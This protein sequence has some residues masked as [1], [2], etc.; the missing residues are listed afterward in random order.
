[1]IFYLKCI[2]MNVEC[3]CVFMIRKNIMF[4]NIRS[5]WFY[6]KQIGN[7]NELFKF[8]LSAMEIFHIAR[9]YRSSIQFLNGDV[10]LAH[11]CNNKSKAVLWNCFCFCLFALY[12]SSINSKK[13]KVFVLYLSST[14][15]F[16]F[17]HFVKIAQRLEF[18][19][20]YNRIYIFV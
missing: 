11:Y 6:N 12:F 14:S 15:R 5:N 8:Y 10:Y 3:V 13:I 20:V 17:N 9:P 16:Y 4:T 7:F 2:K 18:F 19:V 1:M